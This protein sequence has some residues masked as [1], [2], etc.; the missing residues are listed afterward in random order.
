MI[1]F[2]LIRKIIT[3]MET[4]PMPATLDGAIILAV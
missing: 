1:V 4:I 3:L 2:S